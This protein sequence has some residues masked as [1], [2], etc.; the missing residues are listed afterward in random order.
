MNKNLSKELRK[1]YRAI[2]SQLICNNKEKNK[3]ISALKTDIGIKIE[4]GSVNSIEDVINIF[5]TP[6]SITSDYEMRNITALKNIRSGIIKS[7]I[8]TAAIIV[9][10]LAAYVAYEVISSHL[11]GTAHVHMDFRVD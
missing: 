6:E 3:I 11:D 5:G 10:L 8:I 1:Y 7:V 4:E 2:K 9:L